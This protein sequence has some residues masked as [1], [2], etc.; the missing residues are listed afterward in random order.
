MIDKKFLFFIPILTTLLLSSCGS[1]DGVALHLFK[2]YDQRASDDLT[3]TFNNLID[4]NTEILSDCKVTNYSQPN[5]SYLPPRLQEFNIERYDVSYICDILSFSI[6]L[7]KKGNIFYLFSPATAPC[8]LVGDV[9]V[10]FHD[11]ADNLVD[12]WY[13]TD[14]S[15]EYWVIAD[16]I[17]Y[18][19]FCT[20]VETKIF[21]EGGD[22][23]K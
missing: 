14:Y 1:C 19:P 23:C 16:H 9:D 2:V 4:E 13:K 5:T 11:T 21:G 3:S 22:H 20:K 7:Y 18:K 10:F 12:T 8:K 6:D 15:L 17:N